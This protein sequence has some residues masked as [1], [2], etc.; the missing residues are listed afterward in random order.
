VFHRLPGPTRDQK[1]E[2][3]QKKAG[4]YEEKRSGGYRRLSLQS[5]TLIICISDMQERERYK[6]G[7]FDQGKF[8]K[9]EILAD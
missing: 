8:R 4:F 2:L 9:G 6:S 1:Y 7:D 3:R 5:I